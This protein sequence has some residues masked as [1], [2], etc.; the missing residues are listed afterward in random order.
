LATYAVLPSG[1]N[2][3]KDGALP[4]EE[5]ENPGERDSPLIKKVP[6]FSSGCN[7]PSIIQKKDTIHLK[8]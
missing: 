4:K 6:T 3:I 7:P 5:E 2:E 1:A 8:W